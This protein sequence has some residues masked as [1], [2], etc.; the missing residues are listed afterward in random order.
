MRQSE[1]ACNAKIIAQRLQTRVKPASQPQFEHLR[2]PKESSMLGIMR[3][4]N[5]CG[6]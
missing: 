2:Y 1:I 4:K 5:E 6:K 3:G